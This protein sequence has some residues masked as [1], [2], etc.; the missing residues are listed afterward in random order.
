MRN[1]K[2]EH[3]TDQLPFRHE[4]HKR[5]VTRREFLAQGFIGGMG[6][7]VGT[8]L[9]GVFGNSQEA[10]AAAAECGIT[11]GPAA[12]GKIPF[13]CFDLAGGA[14]IAGSNVLVGKQGGQEDFLDDAG[15]SKLGLGAAMTP[16][17]GN[18]DRQLGLLFAA[19]SAMLA[20]ILQKTAVDTRAKV[21]GAVMCTRSNDDTQN[22]PHN[23]MYGIAK[24]GAKGQLATL[25]GSQNT[26]SGGNS[27]A[28]AS[29]IDAALLPTKV[30]SV[31]DAKG[32][33]DTGKLAQ[34]LGGQGAVNVMQVVERLSFVKGGKIPEADVVKNLLGCAYSGTTKQVEQ[35]GNPEI[36]DPRSDL[37][38]TAVFNAQELADGD[39]IKTAAIMKL[40]INGYAAA[41]TIQMGGFDY[42]TGNRTAG[43]AKDLKAGR[44]I[45]AVLE[46]AK[47]RQRPVMIYV[48]T[49]G[50]V[51]SNGEVDDANGKLV[52]TSDNSTT[53]AAFFLVYN[54]VARPT[55]NNAVGAVPRQLGYY[56]ATGAVETAAAPFSNNVN[57]LAEAVVL[58]Y[59]ALH[60]EVGRF[61][62][63]LP[64]QGLGA[65][66]T[67][68]QY[69]AFE[70][71]V[72]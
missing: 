29:M 55:L 70:P 66:S 20:G 49:D 68:D 39:F 12:V 33:V 69:V 8:S 27:I 37:D 32:L 62:Q 34:L 43:E 36:L 22:N 7:A 40:V 28:P 19:D 41:G 64:T 24:A 18:I 25:I 65:A 53:A 47:R 71:I 14:N 4:N 10:L 45:G 2:I 61:A 51:S 52:W 11:A 1:R 9:L 16:K 3:S 23:P 17:V 15:Y 63:I 42:H 6:L 21:D 56:R 59:L 30:A 35:F 72:G 31:N 58:N 50:S 57:Q 13:I 46:Y 38:V 44:A 26:T 54:P 67:W 60:N 48:F 5:P